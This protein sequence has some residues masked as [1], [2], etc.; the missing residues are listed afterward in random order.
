M[1]SIVVSEPAACRP[2]LVDF[3]H[4]GSN[5]SSAFP[6]ALALGF[7]PNRHEPPPHFRSENP[8]P[9]ATTNHSSSIIQRQTTTMGE[10]PNRLVLINSVSPAL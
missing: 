2:I 6:L 8:R 10:C 3:V 5:L 4:T 9:Q 1:S 7:L